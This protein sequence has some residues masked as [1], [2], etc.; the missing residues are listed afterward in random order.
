MYSKVSKSLLI[1]IALI[2]SILLNLPR[3]IEVFIVN[4]NKTLGLSLKETILN[5][6]FL[7]LTSIL[8]LTINAN[9]RYQ[10]KK[11]P[12]Y[13]EVILTIV[14]HV[15]IYFSVIQLLLISFPLLV[16]H[17]PE[18][19][20]FVYFGYGIVF[21][22]LYFIAKIV[23]YQLV[24]KEDVLEKEILKRQSIQNELMALK[25]QINPH[26][27]FNS[28]NSLNSLI[29]DNTA[30][31]TFVN[32]LS[33]MYRYILQSKEKELVTIK[34]ELTFLESYIHLLKVRF[35]DRF[36]VII[37][38]D[39]KYIEDTLPILSLQLL[40][41]NAVKHNEISKE[42]PLYIYVFTENGYLIVKNKIKLKKT[43][44]A[45]TGQG[46]NNINKRSVLLKKKE[47][48]INKSTEYFKV[49]LPLNM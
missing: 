34:E 1:S 49:S 43:L 42:N 15:C 12:I 37:T 2:V 33:F 30:A 3:I 46:L 11:V 20:G 9:W 29:R 35:R 47:I 5:L 22:L 31:T 41:E 48:L 24:H 23:R 26:F 28:L 7:F 38:I 10:F 27:L 8:L 6:V 36:E 44:A 19:I 14:L 32:Q 13:I 25:N 40:V 45:S 16:G 18:K 39:H 4:E 21:I 17:R